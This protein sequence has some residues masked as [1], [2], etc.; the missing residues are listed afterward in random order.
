M[1]ADT[2]HAIVKDWT[3][4]VSGHQRPAKLHD[5]DH[6]RLDAWADYIALCDNYADGKLLDIGI[7]IN[8]RAV[9]QALDAE[10]NRLYNVWQTSMGEC[11]CRPIDADREYTCLSCRAKHELNGDGDMP[12]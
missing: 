2:H 4:L 9:A 1:I 8:A 7:V 3:G 5:A 12:F 11:E 10:Y 6:A